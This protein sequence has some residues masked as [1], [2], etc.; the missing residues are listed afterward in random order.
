MMSDH[1]Y[2]DDRMVEVMRSRRRAGE[3]IESIAADYRKSPETIYFLTKQRVVSL[4]IPGQPVPKGRPRITTRN[5]KPR[6][7]TPEKTRAYEA[8]IAAVAL[9]KGHWVMTGPLRVE[10]VAVFA[11]PQRIKAEGRTPHDKRPDL[12]NIIKSGIDGL[13]R[14]FDDGQVVELR[15]EKFYAARGEEPHATIR[16]LEVE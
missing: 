2:Y 11:R 16:I 10:I 9:A 8:T 15:A 5:G 3:S 4:Y 13:S 7:I 6:G 14:H 12:D 1:G